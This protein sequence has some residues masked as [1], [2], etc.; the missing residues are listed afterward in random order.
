MKKRDGIQRGFFFFFCLPIYLRLRF[1]FDLLENLGKFWGI[2]R[3]I[4][5]GQIEVGFKFLCYASSL[6]L[7][8]RFHVSEKLGIFWVNFRVIFG[9][10]L[11]KLW[12]NKT[13]AN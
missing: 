4:K 3:R 5:L 8:F 12:E 13:W 7:G 10:N 6:R 1:C 2:Y 9:E 11:G